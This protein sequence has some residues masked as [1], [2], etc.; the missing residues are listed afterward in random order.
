MS[1]GIEVSGDSVEVLIEKNSPVPI[2]KTQVFTTQIDNQKQMR[3]AVC[4]GESKK[5]SE[6]ILLGKFSLTNLPDGPAHSLQVEVTF[7]IDV[8]G[9]LSITAKELKNQ[10]AIFVN[11][12]N[13]YLRSQVDDI[14]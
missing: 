7:S 3:I 9:V 5:F 10:N 8:D 4:Q 6:N 12:N 1:F 14:Q 11:F 13:S 2:S